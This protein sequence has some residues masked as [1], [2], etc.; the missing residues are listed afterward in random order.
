MI[1]LIASD[2]DGTLLSS[3]LSISEGN[4]QAI[5]AAQ[6]QGIEFMVA[7]GRDHTEARPSLEEA[8]IK[9]GMITGN[10]AQAFDKE[11]NLLFTVGL[12][13]DIVQEVI[14]IL[15]KNNLYFELMT[16]DGVYAD[17]REARLE[18]IASLVAENIP[19]ITF[20][21]AI[22]MAS[23][24]LETLKVTYVESYDELL[25]RSDVE[26]LKIIT[27]SD[28]GQVK[29]GPVAEELHHNK[30]IYVT[31]SFS[32]NLE[33]NHRDARKGYAVKHVADMLGILMDDVL[34]IGDNYND[35]SM[36]EEAGVSFAMGNGEQIVKDTAKYLAETNV[37]DGVGKAITRAIEENL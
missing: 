4:K 21:M 2:M 13:F 32:N 26:V 17:S 35:L 15:K 29:L 19:H 28:K 24:H 25:K 18:N 12:T 16:T 36:L 9:C 30:N 22:A 37:N 11:G 3:N 31:S 8:G 20:K 34:A 5:L 33:V 27:F 14:T 23:A 1:K 7:T 10:G 6:E